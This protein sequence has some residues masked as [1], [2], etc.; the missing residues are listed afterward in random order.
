MQE[1]EETCSTPHGKSLA[2]LGM[3]PRFPAFH[4]PTQWIVTLVK[5][6]TSGSYSGKSWD[7]YS[8]R[9]I[10]IRHPDLHFQKRS[11]SMTG[12]LFRRSEASGM[13][14]SCFE[15]LATYNST[16][17]DTALNQIARLAF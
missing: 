2:D 5:E 6:K 10:G 13:V 11:A 12:Q 16:V 7:F 1:G 4:C 8:K 14:R 9:E 15:Y 17:R 3:K